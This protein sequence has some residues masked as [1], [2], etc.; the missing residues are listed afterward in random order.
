MDRVRFRRS[1]QSAP[2]FQPVPHSGLTARPLIRFRSVAA[3]RLTA[4]AGEPWPLLAG[5]LLANAEAGSGLVPAV[6]AGYL[7]HVLAFLR[8]RCLAGVPSALPVP[9]VRNVSTIAAMRLGS[10][11]R[12]RWPPW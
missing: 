10:E 3:T 11:T 6:L 9:A 8:R 12:S 1:R 7:C 5:A 2:V 4:G